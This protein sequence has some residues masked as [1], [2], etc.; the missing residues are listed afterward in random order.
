[1]GERER[2]LL[3]LYWNIFVVGWGQLFLLQD[4]LASTCLISFGF[5]P[6]LYC[7]TCNCPQKGRETGFCLRYCWGNSPN[8]MF[9]TP[10][11]HLSR[12]ASQEGDGMQLLLPLSSYLSTLKRRWGRGGGDKRQKTKQKSNSSLTIKEHRTGV[13]W[14]SLNISPAICRGGPLGRV[15]GKEHLRLCIA[16]P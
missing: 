2:E 16:A 5:W 10:R 15:F 11:T 7:A 9:R 8:S 3:S 4:R 13:W 1:M 14:G 6:S 12:T